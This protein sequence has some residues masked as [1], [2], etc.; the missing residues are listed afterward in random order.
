MYSGIMHDRFLFLTLACFSNIC[1]PLEVSSKRPVSWKRKVV[2]VPAMKRRDPR[3]ETLSGKFN[4]DLF[5]KSYGFIK[6]IQSEEKRALQKELAHCTDATES[7]RLIKTLESIQNR[8]SASQHK[9]VQQTIKREWRKQELKNIEEGVKKKPF[10][11]KKSEERK[12]FLLNKFK[13]KTDQDLDHLL[14]KKRKRNAGK[15]RK[16]LP[17]VKNV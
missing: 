10:F 14:E 16:F 6:D 17:A 2:E 8:E 4:E 15:I 13:N 3:F 1:S 12:L 9:Q 11:L 5:N 7:H